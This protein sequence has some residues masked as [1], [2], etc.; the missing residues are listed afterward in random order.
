MATSYDVR[1]WKTEQCTGQRGTTYK[2]RW[3]VAGRQCKK[4]FRTKALAD[5]FRSELMAALRKGQAFDTTTGRPFAGREA[6]E[7]ES[8]YVFACSYVDMKWPDSAGKSRMGIAETLATVTPILAEGRGRPSEKNMRT[9]LYGWA[10]NTRARAHGDPPAEIAPTI[11]W[12]EKNTMQVSELMKP[13]VL[14]TVLA[15]IGRKLDGRPAA[16][17]TTGRKRAVLHNALEYAVER[18]LLPQNPLTALKTKKPRTVEAVDKRVVVSPDQAARLLD[19]VRGQGRTGQHLVL[20]FALLYYA[21]LRPAEAAVL[22]KGDLVIPEQ[23][24]GEL[25]LPKSAPTTGAAWA[26]SGQRRDQRGLKHRPREEVR[27]V[28]CAPPLTELLHQHLAEFGP[29][30]DGRLLRGMRGDDLSDSTYGRVWQK[31]RETALTPE[32]AASPLAR[33]PY[34]LRHAAVSTWLNGGVAPTQVAEWAGHSV[35][36]LLRVYAKCIAGQG[37]AAREQI[38]RALGLG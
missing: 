15:R 32:E 35:A 12:L 10:F 11:Q 17:S 1:I 14:R 31:A 9:A 29:G 30:P 18:E 24:W 28:P 22:G 38:G 4:A 20:F 33:R 8:W 27:V 2:V 25:Y 26:D 19:A 13:D 16:A 21:A 7:S 36:V 6:A 34:D 5:S 3:V 37:Q 23:G